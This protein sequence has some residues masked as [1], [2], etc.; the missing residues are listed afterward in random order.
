MLFLFSFEIIDKA[1][2][3]ILKDHK[4]VKIRHLITGVNILLVLL[5]RYI[6][7]SGHMDL[8]F[9]CIVESEGEIPYRWAHRESNLMFL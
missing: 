5:V 3:H 9:L 4:V 1:I 6:L 7:R 2:V 8:W